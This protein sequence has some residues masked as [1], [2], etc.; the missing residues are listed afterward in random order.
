MGGHESC[1]ITPVRK[2]IANAPSMRI[3]LLISDSIEKEGWTPPSPEEDW[4]RMPDMEG[5]RIFG[6]PSFGAE[7]LLSR[8]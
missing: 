1:S 3:V 6:R 8:G 7:E 2:V 4:H 5:V